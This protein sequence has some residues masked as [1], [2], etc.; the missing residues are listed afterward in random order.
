MWF[1]HVVFVRKT[2]T[3]TD[4]LVLCDKN[5]NGNTVHNRLRQEKLYITSHFIVRYPKS[6]QTFRKTY[7]TFHSFTVLCT[8]KVWATF[9]LKAFTN[10]KTVQRIAF[11]IEMQTQTFSFYFL[12]MS[13]EQVILSINCNYL[14]QQTVASASNGFVDKSFIK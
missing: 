14:Q 7:Q 13:S 11:R 8:Y 4:Q 9:K 5:W 6:G 10:K 3:N 2:F 1:C 12:S